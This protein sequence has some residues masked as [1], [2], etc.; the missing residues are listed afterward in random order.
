MGLGPD[1]TLVAT[2]PKGIVDPRTGNLIGADDPTFVE[3]DNE[4]AR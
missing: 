1:D 3:I 4:L 2:K